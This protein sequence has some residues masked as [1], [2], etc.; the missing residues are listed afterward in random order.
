M[1]RISAETGAEHSAMCFKDN[2]LH[3]F[4][5]KTYRLELAIPC[6][7]FQQITKKKLQTFI[8]GIKSGKKG[9]PGIGVT[10]HTSQGLNREPRAVHGGAIWGEIAYL[11]GA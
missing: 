2:M 11:A 9:V 6:T 5:S 4:M 1:L 3:C 7:V 8:Y 10:H